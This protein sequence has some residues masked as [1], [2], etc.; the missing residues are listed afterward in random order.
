M[1][2]YRTCFHIIFFSFNPHNSSGARGSIIITSMSHIRILRH[3]KSNWPKITQL[4]SD[5]DEFMIQSE[6]LWGKNWER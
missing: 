4:I 3:R 2:I 6:V 5:R 1:T